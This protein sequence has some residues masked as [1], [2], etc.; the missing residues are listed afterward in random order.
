LVLVENRETNTYPKAAAFASLFVP[1][2]I[3]AK[4]QSLP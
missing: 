3:D 2:T 4:F 1:S